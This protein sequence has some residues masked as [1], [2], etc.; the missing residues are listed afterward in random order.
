[1][2][3]CK[4][5]GIC[6]MTAIYQREL[7]ENKDGISYRLFYTECPVC[8]ELERVDYNDYIPD[9]LVKKFENL[10]SCLDPERRFKRA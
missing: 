8:G 9:S 2:K 5:C 4:H 10:K 1:M 3:H 7:Y 6:F